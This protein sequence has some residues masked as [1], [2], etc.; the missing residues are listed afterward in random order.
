[1]ETQK[2]MSSSK[3]QVQ[4]TAT[5]GNWL[6]EQ[7]LWLSAPVLLFVALALPRER[8]KKH[9][10]NTSIG[11]NTL[12]MHI[13]H[14]ELNIRTGIDLLS[15]WQGRDNTSSGRGCSSRCWGDTS[16]QDVCPKSKMLHIKE[17]FSSL[18]NTYTYNHRDTKSIPGNSLT[19]ARMCFLVLSCW[20]FSSATW[21]AKATLPSSLSMPHCSNNR[22]RLT[23]YLFCV[24]ASNETINATGRDL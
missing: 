11:V 18:H 10:K 5:Q 16:I 23:L 24:M 17:H 21:R 2:V 14:N 3:L 12:I 22:E 13:F 9:R 4:I 20:R 1:M 15:H 6:H 19:Y 7:V 8:R